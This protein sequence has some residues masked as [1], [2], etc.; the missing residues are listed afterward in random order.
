ME[1]EGGSRKRRVRGDGKIGAGAEDKGRGRKMR[2]GGGRGVE[3]EERA[4]WRTQGDRPQ[5]TVVYERPYCG[6][7]L[8]RQRR[9]LVKMISL[10]ARRCCVP[11]LRDT[12][13]ALRNLCVWL[14]RGWPTGGWGVP[15]QRGAVKGEA[16]ILAPWSLK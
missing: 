7:L 9:G 12:N 8:P 16:E 4:H 14:I 5:M 11:Y 1:G 15:G 3:G 13:A 6:L 2:G 10:L